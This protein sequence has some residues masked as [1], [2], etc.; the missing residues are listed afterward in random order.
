V[1]YELFLV[2]REGNVATVTF[3]RPPVNA[4]NAELVHQLYNVIEELDE[5]KNIR[6]IVLTGSG[7]A[8]VA[9]A[10]I[11]E[12]RDMSPL[13]AREFARNGHRTLSRMERSEK[14][15]IC[16]INGFALGGGC[17]IALAC[18]IRIMAETAKIGQPEVNLGIIPGFGGTQRLPRLVGPG[19]A[20]EL[21]F[22][23][24]AIDAQ[25]AL[26]IGLVNKVVAADKVLATAQA[27][28]KKIA[29][30]GPAAIKAAKTAI[31]KGLDVDLA[32]GN[33]LEVEAFGL[34]FGTGEPKEGMTA[35]LEKKPKVW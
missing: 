21:M 27:L 3:N 15:V 24:D 33:A 30:K 13:Q 17:E 9:G 25:E 34:C 7:K 19:I 12:M 35:F 20:K 23:A 2:A 29:G 31:N 6:V 1:F 11:G 16:A 4:L 22:A 10:D 14:P 28:A 8:F 32:A 5:D 26:R 18:D